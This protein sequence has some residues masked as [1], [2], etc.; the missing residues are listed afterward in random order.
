MSTDPDEH[1]RASLESWE[2]ASAGWRERS[3]EISAFGMPVAERMVE[4]L[5]LQPGQR[6]LELAAGLGEIGLMAAERVGPEGRV[7]VSDQAEGMV[8][9]ARERARERGVE[10]V[11]FRVLQ[12]ESIDLDAASVDAVLC[13]WAYMLMVDPLT[14]LQETRRVLRPGGRA[15]LAV[16]DGP[17][18]NPW[19][20][21]PMQSLVEQGLAEIPPPMAPGMFALADRERLGGMLE[22]AG[23]TEI[24]IEPVELLRRNASAEEFWEATLGLSPVLGTLLEGRSEQEIAAVREG[25][26]KRLEPFTAADGAVELPGRAVVAF[27][28]A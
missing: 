15:A 5:E 14:A 21:L 23:F 8:E 9:G 1:R 2:A 12:A 3:R 18:C 4:G 7:I 26:G 25:L 27:A 28:S 24:A 20:T 17:A 22:D 13:R 19:V 11:E 10:N 16:W 6:V